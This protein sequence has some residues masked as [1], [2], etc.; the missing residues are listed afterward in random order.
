M[1]TELLLQPATGHDGAALPTTRPHRRGTRQADKSAKPPIRKPLHDEERMASTT[2]VVL[3]AVVS[4]IDGPRRR[5]DYRHTI[6]A[7][8]GAIP[9]KR[10]NNSIPCGMASFTGPILTTRHRRRL[11][12]HH[13]GT[14][15]LSLCFPLFV[16][17]GARLSCCAGRS[18]EV[19]R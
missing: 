1:A 8:Q 9:D 11:R 10:S 19:R 14:R 16:T 5:G 17:G 6:L 12:S 7:A 18:K 2:E 13:G 15:S 4:P 3:P